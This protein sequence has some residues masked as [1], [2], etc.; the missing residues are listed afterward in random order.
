MTQEYYIKATLDGMKAG[1]NGFQHKMGVTK[2]PK[3][4]KSNELCSDGFHMAKSI[5]DALTYVRCATEFYLC[6]PVGEVY[7]EDDT[8][9]RAD[10]INILWKIPV[11]KFPTYDKSRAAYFKAYTAYDKSY[12]TYDKAYT[13]YDKSRAAYVKA[14]VAWDK[15]SPAYVKSRAA[16]DKAY[17]T[18]DKSRAAYDKA[19]A[20]CDKA[21]AAYDKAC[22]SITMEKILEMYKEERR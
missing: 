16:Y 10:G 22:A 7:T 1:Y 12:A 2:H 15:A 3:P 9:I 20:A 19:C 21:Y 13:T 5:G 8:K 14:Y 17:T 4:D 18:Y 11:E 6:Q